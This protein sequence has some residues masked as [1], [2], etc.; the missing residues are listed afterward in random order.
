MLN[1]GRQVW[2]LISR[3][4]WTVSHGTHTFPPQK[5]ETQHNYKFTLK[6]DYL[7]KSYFSTFIAL[8]LEP[9]ALLALSGYLCQLWIYCLSAPNSPI[10]VFSKIMGAGPANSIPLPTRMTLSFVNKKFVRDT[11]RGRGFS[12][13]YD[14]LLLSAPCS[15][16]FSHCPGPCSKQ[17][18]SR[19]QKLWYNWLT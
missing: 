11:W 17:S 2:N 16:L 3:S 8:S 15:S 14:V 13:W 19:I 4:L 12:S 5:R 10:I 6:C 7:I 18:S 9:T 1:R